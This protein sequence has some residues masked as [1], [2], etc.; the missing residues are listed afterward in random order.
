MPVIGDK[1]ASPLQDDTRPGSA[2]KWEVFQ[3]GVMGRIGCIAAR[4]SVA[5]IILAAARTSE[6]RDGFFSAWSWII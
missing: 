4:L 5:G 2:L 6:G 3:G 1:A